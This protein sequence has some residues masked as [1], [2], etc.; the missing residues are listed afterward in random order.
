LDSLD[1]LTDWLDLSHS[2]L[3]PLLLSHL[4]KQAVLVT[5]A[6]GGTENQAHKENLNKKLYFLFSYKTSRNNEIFKTL[7]NDTKRHNFFLSLIIHNY[8]TDCVYRVTNLLL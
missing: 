4:L 2:S 6:V 5:P 7:K 8:Q 1:E 3:A